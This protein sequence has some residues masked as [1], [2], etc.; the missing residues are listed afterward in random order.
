MKVFV[1]GASGFLGAAVVDALSARHHDVVRLVRRP[2]PATERAV[3][4]IGDVRHPAAWIDALRG[5][6][7]VIHLAAAKGG[8]FHTQFATTVLG[9]EALLG[10]MHTAGVRR[11]VHIST[12]SVYDYRALP[13]GSVLDEDS[14]LEARPLDRDEYAQTKLAQEALVRDFAAQGGEVTVV[15]PGA[16]YGPGNL[17][18]AGMVLV[19]PGD[20]GV[21]YSPRGRL[22][23]TYVD[24]CA[25]AIV[26]AT[27]RREA[28]GTTLNI[29]DD[30]TPSQL[31][32]RRA[33]RRAGLPVPH[34]LPVPYRVARAGADVLAFANRRFL[35]GRA[36][37]PAFAVPAKLDSQYRPLRYPNQRAKQVLGWQPRYDLAQA[38]ARIAGA[39]S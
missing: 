5:A 16:I 26:L 30:E 9:T 22:K 3:D 38:L 37:F 29:V 27:E 25:D 4:V 12:F 19:L 8:D 23:L 39:R 13:I 10:A 2:Q 28:I 1:T 32:Y 33:M 36:K 21:A 17:W 20:L 18:N 15:R 11:L 7:A 6:D 31:R 24:N 35:G 34:E 14:P